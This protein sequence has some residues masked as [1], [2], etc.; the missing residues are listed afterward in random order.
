MKI[1]FYNY[2]NITLPLFVTIDGSQMRIKDFMYNYGF[3]SGYTA[4]VS[5]TPINGQYVYNFI[6]IVNGAYEFMLGDNIDIEVVDM[7]ANPQ[8]MFNEV[9][10]QNVGDQTGIQAILTDNL[11]TE[12]LPYVNHKI[13]MQNSRMVATSNKPKTK[14]AKAVVP[15]VK[16][17]SPAEAVV[18]KVAETNTEQIAT[19]DKEPLLSFEEVQ[20]PSVKKVEEVHAG[21]EYEEV[22]SAVADSPSIRLPENTP[23][24]ITLPTYD[25]DEVVGPT[26]QSITEK[27]QTTDLK[28]TIIQYTGKPGEAIIQS[29]RAS[30]DLLEKFVALSTQA[31]GEDLVKLYERDNSGILNEWTA[32][33]VE[34]LIPVIKEY[35]MY[36]LDSANKALPDFLAKV[37]AEKA[38]QERLA[39]EKAEQERLALEKAEQEREEYHRLEQERLALEKAEQER[40]EQERLEQENIALE[41]AEQERLEQEKIALEKAE[42]ERLEQERLALE[43]AEQERLKAEQVSTGQALK[44]ETDTAETSTTGKMDILEFLSKGHEFSNMSLKEQLEMID[45][46]TVNV[47]QKSILWNHYPSFVDGVETH[48]IYQLDE[49][50]FNAGITV[51]YDDS[52][53]KVVPATEFEDLELLPINIINGNGKA[54]KLL[55]LPNQPVQFGEVIMNPLTKVVPLALIEPVI[56]LYLDSQYDADKD[57][58]NS[59]I[60]VGV[61]NELEKVIP[62]F[63]QLINVVDSS[64]ISLMLAMDVPEE[65]TNDLFF[66]YRYAR[67]WNEV[68]YLKKAVNLEVLSI[69]DH[70]VGRDSYSHRAFLDAYILMMTGYKRPADSDEEEEDIGEGATFKEDKP[71]TAHK[72]GARWLREEL[73]RKYLN[74]PTALQAIKDTCVV[75]GEAFSLDE[76]K[77]YQSNNEIKL[78]ASGTEISLHVLG[79]IIDMHRTELLDSD[80]SQQ[81]IKLKSYNETVIGLRSI[82]EFAAAVGRYQVVRAKEPTKLSY[83][84]V[85]A[86]R[87]VS[88]KDP[89]RVLGLPVGL[90]FQEVG[91]PGKYHLVSISGK[92]LSKYNKDFVFMSGTT[93]VTENVVMYNP[94]TDKYTLAVRLF[95]F[96]GTPNPENR[97]ISTAKPF[98]LSKTVYKREDVPV[99]DLLNDFKVRLLDSK[100]TTAVEIHSM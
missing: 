61:I 34:Q 66:R 52:G 40:L 87:V 29:N 38:E 47:P 1:T 69:Q 85:L 8:A 11:M 27:E 2:G 23:V 13:Q 89:T 6:P 74:A 3:N 22:M 24:E 60:A 77:I 80:G 18:N 7:S 99:S 88:E 20:K 28:G 16:Q 76:I 55:G 39:L 50:D 44:F 93:P 12:V 51:P 26:G 37:E 30:V 67:L 35:P 10:Y 86:V 54:R 56:D 17:Q 75:S 57:Y 36:D 42:Q 91:E 19:P 65:Y 45:F 32:E 90:L 41:K 68:Q 33:V 58:R 59:Y 70:L 92:H 25:T 48:S 95:N 31:S 14:P 73:L 94:D 64:I 49:N 4:K 46:P 82:P 43:K 81:K 78:D 21:K 15:E 63:K 62:Q 79:F 9:S 84:T 98:E 71:D 72:Q 96:S 5:A 83:M 100:N 53:A 97:F